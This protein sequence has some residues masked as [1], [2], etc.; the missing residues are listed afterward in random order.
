MDY[1]KYLQTE[2]WNKTRK[3]KLLSRNFCQICSSTKNLHIHHKY[4]K[5]KEGKSILFNEHNTKL[6]TLCGSCHSLWHR[7]IK[8]IRKPNKKILRIKRLMELNVIKNKA[9]WI[10]GNPELYESI[11][12]KLVARL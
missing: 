1:N 3:I 2:H 7:Y 9:F 5:N 4:Y 12:N 6:I 8:E 11:Y 10:V